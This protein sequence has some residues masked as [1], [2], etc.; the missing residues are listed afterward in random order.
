MQPN[1]DKPKT[2]APKL[3]SFFIPHQVS[4]DLND[5]ISVN[6]QKPRSSPWASTQ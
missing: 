4:V 1:S 3:A 6:K 2:Q 5:K